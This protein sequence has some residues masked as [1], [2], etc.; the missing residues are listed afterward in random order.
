MDDSFQGMHKALQQ[1][2]YSTH[3][4]LDNLHSHIALMDSDGRIVTVNE[5]AR[6]Q[7]GLELGDIVGKYFYDAPW[8]AYDPVLQTQIVETVD[9]T[10]LGKKAR[11]DA[12]VEMDSKLVPVDFQISPVRDGNGK[13][14]GSI[15]SA[16]DITERKQSEDR[17]I[18]AASV[19]THAREGILI[20]DTAGS[21]I[22]VN[23]A[24]CRITGY[25]R[26][27]ALG[28]NPRI[29]QSG[30]QSKD[31]YAAMWKS[32]LE[33][34][35][36]SGEL[37]NR[38]KNGDV[39]AQMA[40]ISAICDVNGETQSYVSLF[41]D[42]TPMKEQKK[43]LEHIAHYDVLTNLP[44]RVLLAD[45]LKQIMSQSEQ[46]LAVAYL[47]LDGFKTINDSHGHEVGD[48]L[49]IALSQRMKEVLRKGDTLARIGGDEFVAVLIGI[50]RMADCEPILTHLLQATA[51][52]VTVENTTLQ[53]SASI[54]VT[55]YPQD[56]ADAEQLMRHADQAMYVAKQTGKN[57]YHLF[58]VH[59]DAAIKTQR[60]SLERIR[61]ALER[62][63]FVLY[64][65]PKVNMQN[66]EVLGAEALIRWQH[67]ERGLVPPET[68]C[69]S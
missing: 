26:K 63:E 34:K 69:P 48:Q 4:I 7:S 49:L 24:F 65:Q 23:D 28:K 68:S 6:R 56:E 32:L 35:Y 41:T 50:E 27:E 60:E 11:F 22:E 17:L 29:F 51:D 64:Y 33:R 3:T 46:S 16:L 67:P 45:R 36:W 12:V 55:L 30:R 61:R 43:Q 44:N 39:F 1:G 66:G 42:I 21:I 13:I 47:D 54:G 2:A 37:W 9:A 53:V 57:R 25:S 62:H 19:F 18:L 31:F 58:D 40:T 52:P 5:T 8:W 15:A 14:V 20:T 10:K 59:Q 38:R